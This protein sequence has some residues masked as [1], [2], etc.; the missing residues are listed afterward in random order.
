MR[1]DL[2]GVT[3]AADGSVPLVVTGFDPGDHQLRSNDVEVAGRAGAVPAVDLDAS[4]L[5]QFEIAALGESDTEALGHVAELASA[6][7]PAALSRPGELVPLRYEL[8]GR[9][10]RVY[11]R[12]GAW[13]DTDGSFTPQGVAEILAAFR[14]LDPAFYA[15]VEDSVSL[16][17]VPAESALLMF[18]A[19]PPFLW[20][21]AGGE[22]SRWAVVGGDAVARPRVTFYGPVTRPWVRVGGVL[23]E[24]TGTIAYDDSVTVD[25]LARTVTHA[26]GSRAGG[27][28]SPRTR[29]SD[30]KLSPGSHEVTF[31]GDDITGTATVEVAWRSAY[32]SI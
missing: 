7:R 8:A 13:S 9:S 27:L 4:R 2:S 16:G 18:P 10:R 21:S 5:W 14:V 1:F 32:N 15:D 25:A 19:T 28:V 26:D 20:R 22:S 23:V 30:L 31:G 17:I 29:I 11:G 6:W 24:L 3:F 12:P